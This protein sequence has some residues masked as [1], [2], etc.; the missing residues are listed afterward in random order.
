[1]GTAIER[2]LERTLAAT[3]IGY[4]CAVNKRIELPFDLKEQLFRIYQESLNNAIKH[5]GCANI[6]VEMYAVGRRLKLSISDDG[7]GFNVEDKRDL[8][9]GLSTMRERASLANA[10]YRLDSTMGRGTKVK[11]EVTLD[12]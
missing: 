2:H 3:E 1:L 8:G 10:V 9:L 6:S 5:A 12:D 11:I 4:D 7:Q